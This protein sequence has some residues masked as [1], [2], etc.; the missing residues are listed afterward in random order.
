MKSRPLY[1]VDVFTKAKYTGNQL[2]VI[3][4]AD[5]L[6]KEEMLEITREMNYSET[7]FIISDEKRNGGWDVRIFTMDREL[8]FAG[9]PTLG[10][11]Y[12]IQK[13]IAGDK[14]KEI[15]LNL[16]AGQ[17]PVTVDP[18]DESILWMKQNQPEFRKTYERAVIADILET[19][20]K[21]I[22]ERFPVQNVSTGISFIIVP[23]KSLSAIKKLKRNWEKFKDLPKMDDAVGTLVF[24]P[25]T[26]NKE[27]DINARVFTDIED[28][29]EDPATGSANGCF[30]AYLAKNR[31]FGDANVDARIEQGYEIGRPS[32]LYLKSEDRGSEVDVYVGGSVVMIARG[33][34]L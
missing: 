20:E 29:P 9:H 31:Y 30:A 7:S 1:I 16:K 6:T 10:T 14:E 18:A 33:E 19:D 3:R 15:R 28:I 25:E 34:L 24:A 27:N 23:F 26:Y 22:D 11:A 13:E 12:V 32:L 4:N 8:P 5:G 21:E 2:A 17:I